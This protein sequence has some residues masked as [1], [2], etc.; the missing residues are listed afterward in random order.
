M[1]YL[2]GCLT[3]LLLGTAAPLT[4]QVHGKKII[5]EGTEYIVA[6]PTVIPHP[7][8]KP[9][10]PASMLILFCHDSARVSITTPAASID[11]PRFEKQLTLEPNKRTIVSV[12]T[13]YNNNISSVR[14]GYGIRITSD[15]PLSVY[16]YQ[17]WFGNGELARHLPVRFWGLEHTSCNL[18]L[19]RYVE[20]TK[21]EYRTSQIVV[22]SQA[23]ATDVEIQSKVPLKESADVV[24]I[25]PGKYQLHLNRYETMVL[26]TKVDTQQLKLWSSDPSGA[27]ITSNRPIAVIS[28]HTKGAVMEMPD[29]LPPNGAF[30][31]AASF[32]RNNIHDV[33][34]P[35]SFGGTEFIT[36][37]CL[38]TPTRD[39]QG[40]LPQYG[41]GDDR[42]DVIRIIAI[43]DSTKVSIVSQDGISI[44]QVATLKTGE[45]F[46]NISAEL[47]TKYITSKPAMCYQYGKSYAKILPPGHSKES[48]ATQGHPTVES[49]MPMMLT[50]PPLD[51]FITSGQFYS[52]EGMD[53]FFNI[54]FKPEDVGNIKVD[55]KALNS[56]F[57]G[58]MRF[59]AGTPYA[60]IRTPIGQGDHVV[61][62]TN[63]SVR[64]M[65]WTYG[66]L[67]GLQQGRAYGTPIGID[68][69]AKCNDSLIVKDTTKACGSFQ[70]VFNVASA[71][72][73]CGRIADLFITDTLNCIVSTIISTDR[74]QATVTIASRDQS[75]SSS[76]AML[77]QTESG[78]YV[79]HMFEYRPTSVSITGSTD[80]HDQPINISS[81]KLVRVRFPFYKN[82]AEIV[83]IR[84]KNHP[85][86]FSFD[87][88]SAPISTY[89]TIDV[90]V[91]AV[92]G[93][94]IDILDTIVATFDCFSHLVLP[95]HIR[96]VIPSDVQE[97]H[98]S[99][100]I[101]TPHP[102]VTSA[103]Q[104]FT[105]NVPSGYT[106][107]HIY[108]ALGRLVLARDVVGG[109]VVI[110][111][112]AIP[113]S[114]MYS[115][116]LTGSQP[117]VLIPLICLP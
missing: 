114:G 41:M 109:D 88:P 60:Y 32:V 92:V 40:P 13:L 63:E 56:A 11:I 72:P 29:K 43:T 18:Y 17:A 98:N 2:L 19:D 104:H 89:S 62:S 85:E 95:L 23:D 79:S 39:I 46:M 50:V 94:T 38:Y 116:Q 74:K 67:D 52:P 22:V 113:T 16:T 76:A 81:C 111:T 30:N 51:R 28:G 53:N 24:Q 65:A 103:H 35:N 8:E 77:V 87:P 5:T 64:W 68:L 97:E 84:A 105:I 75:E 100:N 107:I 69:S 45:S 34:L 73:E 49:G 3:L 101:I 66:S 33:M 93:D 115:I 20:G 21:E 26:H 61:Q 10:N 78:S 108:D 83:S 54:V 110:P 25:S 6:F 44:V 7:D 70:S 80:F 1:R 86:I 96:G 14:K 71:S 4:A 59:I 55:G 112:D 27:R 58:S 37:P 82:A 106:T 99:H 12:S 36:I 48:E 91:C 90:N 42:G 15:K 9:L 47:A 117:D 102:V 57:G 31:V